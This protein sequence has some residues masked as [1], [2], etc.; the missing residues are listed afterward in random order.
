MVGACVWWARVLLMCFKF[1]CMVG[2]LLRAG[3]DGALLEI[4]HSRNPWVCVLHFIF[5][6]RKRLRP[7]LGRE[8]GEELPA[9]VRM[10]AV[11]VYGCALCTLHFTW[12]GCVCTAAVSAP[13]AAHTQQLTV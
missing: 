10:K 5:A 8:S 7:L 1:L 13:A 6:K 11:R 2:A 12:P 4:P 3:C 9:W